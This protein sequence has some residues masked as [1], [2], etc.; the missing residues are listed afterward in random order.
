MEIKIQ[1]NNYEKMSLNIDRK[2]YYIF[3]SLIG[4]LYLS[5]LQKLWNFKVATQIIAERNVITKFYFF[6]QHV[7]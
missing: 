4:S 2:S 3:I 5:M 6:N 1:N 7:T